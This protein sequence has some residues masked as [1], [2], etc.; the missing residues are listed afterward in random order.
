VTSPHL[1]RHGE[2]PA[3]LLLP[4]RFAIAVGSGKGGV[5]K[6]TVTVNL[7]LA[8]AEGGAA[9]GV[10]DADVYGPNIP[11]M[12]GLTRKEWTGDW[13]LARNPAMGTLPLLP[14]IERYGLKIMSAGFILAE[15]QPMLLSAR[16]VRLLMRQ[17]VQ[18]VDWGHLD[19]LIIDLPPGTGDI[20]Q[21]LLQELAL[22]GAV[23]VVTPQDV[24]HL[25]GK[26]ALQQYR[27]AG[28]PLLGAVENMSGFRCPH[29]GQPVDVFSRVPD[30]RAIWALGVEKLGA[31][32]LDPGVSQAGDRGCPVLV[33]Q[34][35]SPQATAF[36]QIAQRVVDKLHT[37]R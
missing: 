17:L 12:V 30:A 16:T 9:V 10:L 28:V 23:L 8:L 35:D 14:P 25:D 19:Y 6:S 34:T 18:Q 5:G 13:T 24:A 3:P 22:S 37:P 1:Q 29:C 7:A 26:K 4:A 2:G 27:R 15:D 20:Q 21:N 33:A 32:P 36:R 11:L 31:V